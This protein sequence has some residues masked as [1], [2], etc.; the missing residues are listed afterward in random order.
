MYYGILLYIYIYI[1]IY[2]HGFHCAVYGEKCIR[3]VTC[4]MVVNCECLIQISK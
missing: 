4:Y 2:I 1:Y 3:K